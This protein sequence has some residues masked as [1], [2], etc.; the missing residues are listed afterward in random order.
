[1]NYRSTT[2]PKSRIKIRK[3][4][5]GIKYK[6]K[7]NTMIK[8]KI[9]NYYKYKVQYS[10][11]RYSNVSIKLLLFKHFN[12]YMFLLNMFNIYTKYINEVVI[13]FSLILNWK[14]FLILHYMLTTSSKVSLQIVA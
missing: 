2:I 1:M 9:S 4:Q 6:R 13:R 8:V 14:Q 12:C 3:Q 11:L 7:I 5:N 10:L